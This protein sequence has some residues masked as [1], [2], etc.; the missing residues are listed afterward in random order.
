MFDGMTEKK[1]HM[2]NASQSEQEKRSAIDEYCRLDDVMYLK[3]EIL[4]S[5]ALETV[6]F[7]EIPVAT[8]S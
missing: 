7:V 3:T 4:V 5:I 1:H 8:A 6:E 2:N